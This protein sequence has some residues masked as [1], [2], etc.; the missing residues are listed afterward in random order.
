AAPFDASSSGWAWTA[1]SARRSPD[2]SR[3][4]IAGDRTAPGGGS[5]HLIGTV[6]ALSWRSL[7][8]IGALVAVAAVAVPAP[9]ASA[10]GTAPGSLAWKSCGD[11]LQCATL[12]VPVDWSQPSGPQ[13]AL[14]VAR[15][16][17]R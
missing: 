10:A 6:A 13:V 15:R 5:T 8:A 4:V 9:G 17:A 16:P 3:G 12:S 14:A 7:V 11:G 1:R 2:R